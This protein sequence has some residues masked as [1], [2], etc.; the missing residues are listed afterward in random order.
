[1]KHLP[2]FDS[3]WVYRI[4]KVIGLQGYNDYKWDDLQNEPKWTKDITKKSYKYKLHTFIHLICP[5]FIFIH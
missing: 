4:S 2:D 3:Y 5:D 1:M